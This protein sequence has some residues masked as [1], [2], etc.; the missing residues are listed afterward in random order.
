MLVFW[1]LLLLSS[2]QPCW[3]QDTEADLCYEKLEVA[4][5]RASRCEAALDTSMDQEQG[6]IEACLQRAA[7][8]DLRQLLLDLS[9]VSELLERIYQGDSDFAASLDQVKGSQAGQGLI[10]DEIQG[11]F[12]TTLED[13][14]RGEEKH[15]DLADI[16]NKVLGQGRELERHHGRILAALKAL[17]GHAPVC[18]EL[19]EE[20]L[21]WKKES[22]DKDKKLEEC[23]KSCA[24]ILENLRVG[25]SPDKE[26]LS[27]C[28]YMRPVSPGLGDSLSECMVVILP[29][30]L[31]VGV[32]GLVVGCMVV[33]RLRQSC[34]RERKNSV[35]LT[36]ARDKLDI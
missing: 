14:R 18:S 26:V 15:A 6:A 20:L 25:E 16:L 11:K 29:A 12:D 2:A 7:T 35:E 30:F 19:K 17:Q 8:S 21:G 22:E 33:R 3:S 27:L 10:L 4:K 31:A 23:G 1:V 5:E 24:Q 9:R 13:L 28:S 36:N 34:A 32:L